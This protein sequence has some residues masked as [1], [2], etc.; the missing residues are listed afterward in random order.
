LEILELLKT[1]F[2]CGH[3]KPNHKS[4]VGDKTFVYG[5]RSRT[6]LIHQVIP[7]FE[8][9][10]LRTS[11]RHNFEIF[12]EIVRKMEMGMHQSRQGL[13]DLIKLAFSM[14]RK[15][16]YRKLSLDEVIAY[17]EPSETIRQTL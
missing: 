11:K 3:I 16:S 2:G 8:Q 17:L 15:G 6:D 10:P 12:S 5:V 1:I 9:Y 4:K 14:N 7:F 13:I